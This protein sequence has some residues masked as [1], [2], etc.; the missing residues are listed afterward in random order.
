MSDKRGSRKFREAIEEPAVM[1]RNGGQ[2]GM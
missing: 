2:E 1:C